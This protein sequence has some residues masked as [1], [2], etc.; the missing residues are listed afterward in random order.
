MGTATVIHT[1][2]PPTQ[3]DLNSLL[4]TLYDR[5]NGIPQL[6]EDGELVGPVY[7]TAGL[8]S[9]FEGGNT[10]AEGLLV[11]KSDTKQFAVGDGTTPGGLTIGY[12]TSKNSV[13]VQ[14]GTTP[15]ANADNLKFAKLFAATLSP[16]ATNPVYVM[17]PPGV[18][19]FGTG[20]A[21]GYGLV[22]DTPYV[23]FMGLASDPT[24]VRITSMIITHDRATVMQTVDNVHFYNVTMENLETT[25]GPEGQSWYIAAYGPNTDL[26]G[27]VLDN[28]H[29]YVASPGYGDVAMGMRAGIE[30]SGI[31]RR[32]TTNSACSF[33]LSAYTGSGVLS[34]TVDNF[35][36]LTYAESCSNDIISGVIR[37]SQ[38]PPSAFK[39]GTISGLIERCTFSG[40]AFTEFVTV[41]GIIR[42]CVVAGDF[43]TSM[44]VSLTSTSK[45]QQ[46]T[47]GGSVGSNATCAG[48]IENVI[49]AGD[50]CGLITTIAS[51]AVF[52]HCVAAGSGFGC[53]RLAG[54]FEDCSALNG[55]NGAMASDANTVMRRCTVKAGSGITNFKG[56][57]EDCDIRMSGSDLSAVTVA[58]TAKIYRSTLV[59]TGT[60]NSVYAGTAQNAV[61]AGCVMNTAIHANVTNLVATPYNV[62]DSYIA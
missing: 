47:C 49:A 33:G 53:L 21:N 19:D 8:A 25:V 52:R 54:T 46:I 6:D 22:A 3:S 42:D 26:P 59:S 57:M 4:E 10:P 15:T 16:S 11:Y 24:A 9:E 41:S 50:F 37:N 36:A 45:I 7:A 51:T 13:W 40:N 1:Q 29:I 39:S 23:H 61:V 48:L 17:M 20:D 5:P 60:G 30:Y 12:P 34:G 43:L 55:F 35:N 14:P 27:T 28:V 38:F 32:V 56:L 2:R 31:Y 44:N 18:Y 58:S 62:V